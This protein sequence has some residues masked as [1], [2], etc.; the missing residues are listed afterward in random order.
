[1]KKLYCSLSVFLSFSLC[2]AMQKA[3]SSARIRY[4][5]DI[6]LAFAQQ[7]NK[8]NEQM[9]KII[10]KNGIERLSATPL[11]VHRARSYSNESK[12]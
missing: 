7:E 6:L 2:W 4:A 5:R 11:I 12:I 10:E 1:M 3:Q 8:S 9:R